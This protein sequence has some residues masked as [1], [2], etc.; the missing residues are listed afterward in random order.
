MKIRQNMKVNIGITFFLL[1]ILCII[2][3]QFVLMVN[4]ISALTFHEFGHYVAIKRN[5]YSV[6]SFSL[7]MAGAR[8]DL[9]DIVLQKD[10][11]EVS[12]AGPLTNILL[13]VFCIAGW[14]IVPE[15]YFY[16]NTFVY[17]N[18]VLAGFNLLP[19]YPLDGSKIVDSFLVN[20]I[21]KNKLMSI[22]AI[23]CAI[24]SL[25]FMILFVISIFFEINLYFLVFAVFFLLS[26]FS[27]PKQSTILP[28]YK[29]K[30][31]AQKVNI[32]Y[33]PSDSRLI[34]AYMHTSPKEYTIFYVAN[35]FVSEDTIFALIES[36]VEPSKMV[37]RYLKK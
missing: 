36:G 6:K 8:L 16:T 25:F 22:K 10:E 19:I 14:W 1:I 21:S 27:L 3:G 20:K 31:K 30:T 13:A 17:V 11:F 18:I 5:G 34:N 15:S 24:F 2:N 33:L 26:L 28:N 9:N 32:V 35:K 23:I 37:V 29:K 7:S 12:V 4:Y